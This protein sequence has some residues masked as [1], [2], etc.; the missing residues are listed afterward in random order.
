MSGAWA[1]TGRS[2]VGYPERADIELRYVQRWWLWADVSILWRTLPAV[3]TR[4][5]AH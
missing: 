2:R 3:I 5:G 1:I 4:R